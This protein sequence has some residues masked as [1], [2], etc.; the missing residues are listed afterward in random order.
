MLHYASSCR[1]A[2]DAIYL[3]TMMLADLFLTYEKA[4]NYNNSMDQHICILL[5]YSFTCMYVACAVSPTSGL[6]WRSDRFA[7]YLSM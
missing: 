3:V 5:Q 4:F 6:V 2:V 1:P 7:N